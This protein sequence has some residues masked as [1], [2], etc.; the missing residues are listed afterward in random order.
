MNDCTLWGEHKLRMYYLFKYSIKKREILK[1]YGLLE[2]LYSNELAQIPYIIDIKYVNHIK[3]W[4]IAIV[5]VLKTVFHPV[6]CSQTKQ[7][8][9]FDHPGWRVFTIHSI[10]HQS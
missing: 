7:T 3:R 4:V 9:I 2:L 6:G 8:E 10:P 1:Q 5:I